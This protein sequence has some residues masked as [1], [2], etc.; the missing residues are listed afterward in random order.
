MEDLEKQLKSAFQKQDAPE[1]FEARVMAAVKRA[2]SE[3]RSHPRWQWLVATAMASVIAIGV[4]LEHQREVKE[5][6]A[7]EAAKAQLEL[8]LKIT[9]VKLQKIQKR[10][11]EAR[12]EEQR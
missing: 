9:S 11:D 4:S 5:R 6:A 10:L 12:G 1:W 3:K 8:A 2:E 7:G